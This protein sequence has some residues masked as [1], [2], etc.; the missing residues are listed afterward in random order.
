MPEFAAPVTVALRIID[1][2]ICNRL[3][4]GTHPRWS[5]MFQPSRPCRQMSWKRLQWNATKH[6][7]S[8]DRPLSC[9]PLALCAQNG[10]HLIWSQHCS[11]SDELDTMHDDDLMTPS[12]EFDAKACRL[13][14]NKLTSGWMPINDVGYHL[15]RLEQTCLVCLCRQS[16]IR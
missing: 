6:S 15:L 9:L 10:T 14:A 12:D 16:S 4:K 8:H 3:T 5:S 7:D 11:L 1:A 2:W 13:T